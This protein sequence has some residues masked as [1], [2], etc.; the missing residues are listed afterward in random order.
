MRRMRV[1]SK[2][3]SLELLLAIL[4]KAGPTFKTSPKFVACVKQ[5]C[6][7]YFLIVLRIV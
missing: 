4:G 5:V 1:Q 6:C 7:P 2:V 3:L